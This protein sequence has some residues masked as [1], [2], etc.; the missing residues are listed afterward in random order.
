MHDDQHNPVLGPLGV[1]EHGVRQFLGD[2]LARLEHNHPAL[3]EQRGAD[4]LRK[5][6]NGEFRHFPAGEFGRGI[7][8]P[9]R[10]ESGT[11]STLDEKFFVA[12]DQVQ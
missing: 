7:D 2:V 5:L 12:E 8:P 10:I 3:A 9:Y 4:Q 6:S 1:V 11:N